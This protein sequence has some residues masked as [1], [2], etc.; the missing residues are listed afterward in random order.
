MVNYNFCNRIQIHYL[1]EDDSHTIDANV[2]NKTEYEVLG[3]I[4]EIVT[5]LKLDVDIETEPIENGS[6]RSWLKLK[7]NNKNA[8]IADTIKIAVVAGILTNVLATPVTTTMNTLIT[9]GLERIFES[10]EIRE[11]KEKKQIE[12]LKLDIALLQQETQRLSASI[13]ENV[14]KKRTSN[15]YQ[16]LEPYKKVNQVSFCTATADKGIV[17]I[18]DVP[19]QSFAS[20]IL[21]SDD[22]EPEIDEHA[23]IEIISPVLKKGKYKWTGYYSNGIISFSM[24][25]EEFK[26]AVQSGEIGFKNGFTIDCVLEICKKIDDEG[27]VI[28][29]KYNVKYINSYFENGLPIETAEG[30]KRRRKKEANKLQLEFCFDE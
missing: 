15:F 12:E 19:R 3:L 8:T 28:P 18:Y 23:I 10:K 13:D 14:I 21:K 11:L 29:Y 5:K 7:A 25:S 20:F 16:T 6:I 17:D 2:F 24:Q 4:K 27:R 26:D 30:K 9:R 22:L 1:F